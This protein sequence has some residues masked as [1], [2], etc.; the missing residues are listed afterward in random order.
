MNAKASERCTV[1]DVIGPAAYTAGQTINS[2]LFDMGNYDTVLAVL[3]A[4]A[5]AESASIQGRWQ[6]GEDTAA[7]SIATLAAPT[8]HAPLGTAQANK[9]VILDLRA[10]QLPEGKRYVRLQLVTGAL[11]TAGAINAFAIVQGFDA[12]HAPG[13]HSSD[14]IAVV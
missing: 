5:V 10:E 4:G 11:G 8:A 1:L 12:R 3:G 7:S 2:V 13:A 6:A 14:V 9:A